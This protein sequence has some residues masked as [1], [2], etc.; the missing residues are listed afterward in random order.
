MNNRMKSTNKALNVSIVVNVLALLA[1]FTLLWFFLWKD[2]EVSIVA[3]SQ[4][5]AVSKAEVKSQV[6]AEVKKTPLKKLTLYEKINLE[7]G[8]NN[9]F[10]K[11]VMNKQVVAPKKLAEVKSLDEISDIEIVQYIKNNNYVRPEKHISKEDVAAVKIMKSTKKLN[12][13]NFNSVDV[14]GLK[15]STEKVDSIASRIISLIS[16]KKVLNSTHSVKLK[17]WNNS[18]DLIKSAGKAKK[19]GANNYIDVIKSAGKARKNEMRTIRIKAGES[20]WEIAARAYGDGNLYTKIFKENPQLTNPDLIV[21][22]DM[23]RVPL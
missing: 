21:A 1:I 17:A 6:E 13:N 8:T 10:L 22:G 14:S 5:E 19:K 9:K 20:L 23:L 11:E 16:D 7:I 15:N 18:I 2:Q 12:I 3:K 4:V